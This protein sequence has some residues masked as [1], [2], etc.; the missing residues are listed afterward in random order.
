MVDGDEMRHYVD[1]IEEISAAIDY[2]PQGAG[3]SSVGMR[4]N[5]VYWFK[6]AIF[7]ARFTPQALGPDE[8]L[9]SMP[10]S[11]RGR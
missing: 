4:L 1:G 10:P 7:E 6:G 5:Q 3:R 11:A 2:K 8:F 9:A